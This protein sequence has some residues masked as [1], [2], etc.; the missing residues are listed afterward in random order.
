MVVICRSW[1]GRSSRQL[2]SAH[3]SAGRVRQALLL[4]DEAAELSEHVSD[5]RARMRHLGNR[6]ALLRELGKGAEARATLNRCLALRPERPTPGEEARWKAGASPGTSSDTSWKPSE[7]NTR[8]LGS[9]T[10]GP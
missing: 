5:D 9:P 6:A 10:C 7:T 4:L 3:Y 2:A 8:P 1:A